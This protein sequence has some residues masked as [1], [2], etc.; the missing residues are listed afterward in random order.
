MPAFLGLG[1]TTGTY[2]ERVA[3]SSPSL[4]QVFYQT[5][6]DEY[7]KYVSYGGSNRWVQSDVKSARRLNINGDFKVWQRGTSG[8]NGYVADRWS[9]FNTSSTYR[10]TDVPTGF[11][12]SL[13][14]ENSGTNQ[15]GILQ[16]LEGADVSHLV[17]KY[18]TVSFW[19]KNIS[20]S[21]N[22]YARYYTPTALDNWGGIN[23]FPLVEVSS[24]PSTSWTYYSAT[25]LMPASVANGLQITV[26]RGSGAA[27]AMRVTG[28]Q[29]E[30]G[31]AP[32]EFEFKSYADELARC[33]R[34]YCIIKS[35]TSNSPALFRTNSPFLGNLYHCSFSLPVSPRINNGISFPDLQ[36]G[37]YRIHKP[38]VR[39]DNYS[40]ISYEAIP[41]N[42]VNYQMWVTPSV[43]D[44]SSYYVCYLYGVGIIYNGEF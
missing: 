24:N 21:T 39:W 3:L 31:T 40:S 1:F 4:G 35:N 42:D 16:R 37:S 33:Q 26:E 8:A 30:V 29:V 20:G 34:Y 11:V 38:G 10:S 12:Y 27:V 13:H 9:G 25:F 22:L 36:G 41:G 28:I 5:D 44:G 32:S 23:S 18:I 43:D 2:A 15:I 6:T 17:G 19:A 7:L 14:Y